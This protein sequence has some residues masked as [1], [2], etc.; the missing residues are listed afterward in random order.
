METK[1]CSICSQQKPISDYTAQAKA[2]CSRC[3]TAR[4]WQHANRQVRKTNA[5]EDLQA[6]NNTMHT[7]I[8][9]QS[10]ECKR[11]QNLLAA[12]QQPEALN[13][14]DQLLNR[15]AQLSSLHADVSTPLRPTP[16]NHPTKGLPTHLQSTV[17]SNIILEDELNNQRSHYMFGAGN[18][19]APCQ[20][21]NSGP[22]L[23]ADSDWVRLHSRH[24]RHSRHSGAA[25]S[26]LASVSHSCQS[27]LLSI[28]FHSYPSEI[29]SLPSA[30]S[31]SLL[32][33]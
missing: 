32:P 11:L 17:R 23:S 9:D 3:L 1:Q 8:A 19:S 10:A 14:D 2:T 4:R 25:M 7:T 24:S 13:L 29:L 20:H 12:L 15:L 5:R 21:S 30:Q 27:I 26:D 31:H 16:R 33:I 28:S 22:I 18:Y 6:E